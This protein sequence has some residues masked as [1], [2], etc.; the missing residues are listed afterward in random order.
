MAY[1]LENNITAFDWLKMYA[2]VIGNTDFNSVIEDY[3]YTTQQLKAREK[4]TDRDMLMGVNPDF[5]Y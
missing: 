2:K 4:Q 5:E 1:E 3:H